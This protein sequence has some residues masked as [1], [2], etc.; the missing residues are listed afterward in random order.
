MPEVGAAV[1]E[2][3][4]EEV[5]EPEPDLEVERV[6]VPPVSGPDRGLRLD[7]DPEHRSDPDRALRSAP[8]PQR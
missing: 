3:E 4:P 6:P 5:P 7:R 1:G 2:E 8:A